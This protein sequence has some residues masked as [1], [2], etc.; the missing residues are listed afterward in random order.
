MGQNSVHGEGTRRRVPRARELGW[1]DD[2]Y[3]AGE[4]TG[5]GG[6]AGSDG[7]SGDTGSS[8]TSASASTRAERRRGGSGGGSGPGAGGDG[9][10][11]HRRGGS[12][13][14]AKKAGKRKVLRWVAITLAVLI[15]GTAG[16]GYLYYEHLNG[17]IRSGD[18]AGG[19]SGV[20]KAAPNALG[21][22]PLNILLIGSDDRSDE[23]NIALGGGRN[24]KDRKPLADV[25]MLLHVSADR[26]NAS[27]ISIPRDTVVKIPECKDE[28][29]T[30]YAATTNRPI[31]ESLQRGGPGCTLTTW[32][33]LTGVYIDHWLMVDFVGVVAMADEIGGVPVCVT[34][35]VHDKST[36]RV[37]G[38]SGLKLR[39]GTTEIKG[40][41]ALQWLRTRHAFG[42]DQNRAKAQHMYM[43]GM[44]KKLQEQ[45]AWTD[46]GRL[47]GLAE[48]AT[49]SLKV[50]QDL[51]T[52]KKLFD[53]SMQLKNVKID[54]LTTA[55]VPT[56]PYLPNPDAWLQLRPSAADKMWAMLRDDVAYDKNGDKS[57]AEAKP[58]TTASAKPKTPA[59]APGSFAVTVVNG[60]DGGGEPAVEGRAGNMAEALRGKGFTQADSSQEGGGRKDTVVTYPKADGDQ[61]KANALS[62]TK[63]LG[64]PDS[65]ARADVEAKGITLVVGADWR[66][67]TT[68]KKPTTVAG[69]LPEGADDKAK[70]MDIYSVYKWDGKS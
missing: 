19:S 26:E 17:N 34:S 24:D 33:S 14:R 38:G 37:K 46:T 25:Q 52:V 6:Q 28:D 36:A 60:T 66:E 11:G 43:N 50:S 39:E 3:D 23:K 47:T 31:N 5:A 48:T 27:L 16:A 58:K 12:R 13:R 55:T 7:A 49:K 18:R 2:L 53:L 65:A 40:V 8:G 32:E 22:T 45:N 10:T 9:R 62:V 51:D 30:P 21:D 64:L 69:D 35:G 29:G 63:A 42:S 4:A 41:Q 67:G 59:E 54:R 15:L 57:G 68:Y 20:K 70:C 44:M 1:D 61:G 56:D